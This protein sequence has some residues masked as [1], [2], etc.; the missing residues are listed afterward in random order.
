MKNIIHAGFDWIIPII[1]I[2]VAIVQVLTKGKKIASGE[3][4]PPEKVGNEWDDLLE[5]LGQKEKKLPPAQPP[6]LPPPV[7]TKT[8]KQ[9]PKKQPPKPVAKAPSPKM[10]E[11]DEF[12][13]RHMVELPS[14]ETDAEKKK[15]PQQPSRPILEEPLEIASQ[16]RHHI[17]AIL[18]NQQTIRD[19]ILV[20]EIL[21]PPLALRS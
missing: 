21:S 15:I 11:E 14:E 2:L 16:R 19:A 18:E 6:P 1:F 17:L 9:P 12:A 20:N 3:A 13:G 8:S 10:M 7:V 5:A 4:P